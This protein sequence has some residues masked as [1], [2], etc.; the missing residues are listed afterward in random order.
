MS[1]L[2]PIVETDLEVIRFNEHQGIS[3]ILRYNSTATTRLVIYVKKSHL[4]WVEPSRP[5]T[6]Y[7]R[8]SESLIV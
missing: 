1:L 2:E 7:F 4:F 5:H 3:D 6:S 8:Q